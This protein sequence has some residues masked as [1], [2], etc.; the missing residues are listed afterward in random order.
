[1]YYAPQTFIKNG[2]AYFPSNL[3]HLSTKWVADFSIAIPKEINLNID[4][5]TL[6]LIARIRN[7]SGDGIANE[8]DLS[9]RQSSTNMAFGS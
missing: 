1:M 2:T 9:L 5:D 6:K 4:N 7:I 8:M 3:Y